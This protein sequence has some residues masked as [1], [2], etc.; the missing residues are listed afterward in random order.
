M[1]ELKYPKSYVYD[2]LGSKPRGNLY[3]LKY[4]ADAVIT[5][6]EETLKNSR[7]AHKYWRK[8]YLIEHKE[9]LYQK[10]KR[11]LGMARL[12]LEKRETYGAEREEWCLKW[13]KRW[14]KIAEEFKEAK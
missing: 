11:C 4:E 1:G 10:H 13:Y 5:E 9:C 6:L 7:N 12:S 14:L 3:Y 8:E 2:Q